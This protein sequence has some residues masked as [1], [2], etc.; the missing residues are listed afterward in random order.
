MVSGDDPVL[1]SVTVFAAL[2]VKTAWLPKFSSLGVLIIGPAS[3]PASVN[4]VVVASTPG[5]TIRMKLLPVGLPVT[6]TSVAPSPMKP[7]GALAELAGSR[8]FWAILLPRA[9]LQVAGGRGRAA[10]DLLARRRL[11]GQQRPG[12]VG[13]VAAHAV[14]VG[15]RV[16]GSG[17]EAAGGAELHAAEHDLLTLDRPAGGTAEGPLEV[18]D[19]DQLVAAREGADLRVGGVVERLLG[20]VAG[21]R[22]W[23]GRV[24]RGGAGKTRVVRVDTQLEPGA[25]GVPVPRGVSDV[26]VDRLRDSRCDRRLRGAATHQN[27]HR[28]RGERGCRQHRHRAP[29]AGPSGGTAP[30]S[31]A[32]ATQ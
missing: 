10:A 16:G 17:D 6:G 2:V 21:H 15:D 26:R 3:L 30:G 7:A 31:D 19:P 29:R 5:P 32:P 8:K 4:R 27:R 13:D 23:L 25:V 28:H 11:G 12:R 9:R 14:R 22:G 1:L 20:E 24:R 18:E